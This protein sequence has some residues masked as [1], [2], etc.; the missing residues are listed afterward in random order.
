M[1]SP[2]FFCKLFHHNDAYKTNSHVFSHKLFNWKFNKIHSFKFLMGKMM[3][4]RSR[5]KKREFPHFRREVYFR[6]EMRSKRG[7][8]PPKKGDWTYMSILKR[9]KYF[10]YKGLLLTYMYVGPI[11]GLC[12]GFCLWP[13]PY[14]ILQTYYRPK[15]CQ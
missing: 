7:S 2:N 10:H 6:R 8:L 11:V 13:H 12:G 1:N 5:P 3:D 15:V 14:K 4:R 9:Q